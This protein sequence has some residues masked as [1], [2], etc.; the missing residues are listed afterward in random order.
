MVFIGLISYPLYLWHWPLLSFDNVIDP[1]PVSAPRRMFLLILAAFLAWLTYRFVERPIRS[2]PALVPVAWR[3][4]ALVAVIGTVG[5]VN[6]HGSIP[7]RSARYG[8][9]KI[10][11]AANP[12]SPFRGRASRIS[13][14]LRRRCGGRAQA[15]RRCFSSATASSSNTTPRRLAAAHESEHLRERRVR[16]QRRLSADSERAGGSSPLLPRSGRPSPGVREGPERQYRRDRRK[17]DGLF[18][19]NRPALFLLLC[20]RRQQGSAAARIARL[21]ARDGGAAAMVARLIGEGK[22]VYL[23]PAESPRRRARSSQH[24][25]QAMGCLELSGQHSGDHPGRRDPIDASRRA[26]IAGHSRRNRCTR[27]STRSTICAGSIA[28]S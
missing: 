16:E 3:L 2:N 10:I 15:R 26:A 5:F 24:D 13:I 12:R 20:R 9:D 11:Q 23:H 19:G 1:G 28:P 18:R 6:F 17:L 25:R 7:P 4:A 27:S 14:R 21:S 8:L 22:E